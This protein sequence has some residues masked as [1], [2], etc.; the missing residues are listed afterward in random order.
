MTTTPDKQAYEDKNKKWNMIGKLVK[1]YGTY[2]DKLAWISC[3]ADAAKWRIEKYSST[4]NT[5]KKLETTKKAQ[6]TEE[7]I[8]FVVFS[9]VI[10]VASY[11][12]FKILGIL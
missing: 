10:V 5:I 4:S 3:L 12:T 2:K 7:I 6:K 11:I 9:I 8:V 1:T